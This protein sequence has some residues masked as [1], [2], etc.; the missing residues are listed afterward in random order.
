MPMIISVGL[1]KEKYD[2]YYKIL[3]STQSTDLVS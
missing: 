3:E 2:Y 1:M